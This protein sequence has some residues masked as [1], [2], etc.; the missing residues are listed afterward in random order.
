[1]TIYYMDELGEVGLDIDDNNVVFLG[2]ECY[3]SSNGK[4]YRI[5]VAQLIEIVCFN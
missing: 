1:M 2:G 4:E 5:S 3:F